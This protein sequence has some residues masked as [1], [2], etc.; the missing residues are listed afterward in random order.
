LAES[1]LTGDLKNV[2]DTLPLS[3]FG[4]ASLSFGIG[5]IGSK[6]AANIGSSPIDR[7]RR[8]VLR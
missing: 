6:S 7:D 8:L 1:G 5:G 2:V 3:D 4:L